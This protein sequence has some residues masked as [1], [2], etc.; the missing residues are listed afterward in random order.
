[1]QEHDRELGPIDIAVIAYPV[2]SP[3][4]GDAVPLLLDLVDRGIIRVLD[5]MFVAKEED[6]QF[7]GFEAQDL[8]DKGV[9]DFTVFEGA[10]SGLL[11]QS[12]IAEAAQALEAGEAAA[13]IVYENRWAAPFAAAVR[14]NGGVFVANERVP[15]AA[16]LDALDATQATA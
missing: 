12:D 1:M 6:G 10:T 8:D 2:G 9:G 16:I 5:V 4:T 15:L 7:V 14:R 11:D 3:M 13:V